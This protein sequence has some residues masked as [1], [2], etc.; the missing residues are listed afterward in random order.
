MSGPDDPS[1]IT[2]FGVRAFDFIGGAAGGA[3]AGIIFPRSGIYAFLGSVVV[4]SMTAGYMTAWLTQYTGNFAGGISF[5]VGLCSMGIC[6]GLVQ[7]VKRA[8][9]FDSK[10][11]SN[12]TRP[13]S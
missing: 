3:V 11:T 4:G 13:S 2:Q 7:F 9:P 1:L 12:G 5:V 6:A 8:L 10:G